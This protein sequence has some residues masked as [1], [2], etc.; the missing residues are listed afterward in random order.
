MTTTDDH[1]P[2][3]SWPESRWRRAVDKV[4]TGRSLKPPRWKDGARVCVALSFDPD[5]ETGTLREGSTSPGRLSQGQYGSRAGV[6]RILEV[7][8]KHAIK[9]SFFVP[10]V[11][12]TLYP[13]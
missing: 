5:H 6:P 10:G 2:S 7:L 12:A 1:D 4:R 13:D 11:I 9:A 8:R 3:W